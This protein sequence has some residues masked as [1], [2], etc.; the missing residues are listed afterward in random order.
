M[1]LEILAFACL[2][3]VCDESVHRSKS[4]LRVTWLLGYPEWE[5][6]FSCLDTREM[7]FPE[8]L[9]GENKVFGKSFGLLG[10]ACARDK[11]SYFASPFLFSLGFLGPLPEI[12]R[13][14]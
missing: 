11:S 13:A 6:F 9:T 1:I 10:S 7:F 5:G 4:L 3:S 14:A 12:T 2:F 8:S